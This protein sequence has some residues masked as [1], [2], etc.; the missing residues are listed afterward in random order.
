MSEMVE[1]V[2]RAIQQVRPFPEGDKLATAMAIAAIEAMRE[3]TNRM[4]VLAT[5]YLCDL[6]AHWVEPDHVWRDMIDE[7]LKD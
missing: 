3:P 7:A 5:D 4:C 1:R 6:E 2:K